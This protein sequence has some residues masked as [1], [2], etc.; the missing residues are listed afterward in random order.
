MTRPFDHGLDLMLPGQPGQFTKRLQLAKLGR[1][2]GVGD[3][4]RTQAVAQ[5]ERDI[6]GFHDLTD[7]CKVGIQEVL[8][9]VGQTP[10]GH[11]RATSRDD[12]GQTGGGQRH[13]AQQHPGMNGKI[14]HTLLG[15][16]NQRVTIDF[17]AQLFG[18]PADLFQGLIDR[19]GP[20]RNR[21]ITQ[22]PLACFMN[23]G[24]G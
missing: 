1:I 15:L 18:F 4:A 8:L 13:I 19:H 3:R 22:D 6:V 10:L 12:A 14:I 7:V 16:F 20:D 24:A 23:I 17:P 2:V 9:V 5:A 11:D 21:R